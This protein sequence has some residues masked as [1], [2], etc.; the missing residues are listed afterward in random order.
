MALLLVGVGCRSD[1]GRT[2]EPPPAPAAAAYL[3]EAQRALHRADFASALALVDSAEH[4]ATSDQAS[5]QADVHFL[6]GRIFSEAKRYDEA[7]TAYR[8]AL[9]LNPD[10]RGAWFNLGNNAFRQQQYREAVDHYRRERAAHPSPALLVNLGRA[11][12]EL[13]V[14]DS[15]RWAY[16]EA[17][18]ADASE[19]SAY[20][21]LS[22]LYEDEGRFEDALQQA[23]QALQRDPDNLNYRYLVGSLL[24]QTGQPEA[25]LEHLRPVAEQ[26]P[27]HAAAQ[28]NLGQALIRLGRTDEAQRY[29]AAADSA[30][31]LERDVEQW[32]ALVAADPDEPARWAT[33]AHALRSAGRYDEATRA[34]TSALSLDPEHLAIRNQLASLYLELGDAAS[35][36]AHYQFILQRRP[37]S[38]ET[39]LGLGVALAQQGQLDKARQAWQTVLRYAPDHAEAK[40]YLARLDAPS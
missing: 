28:Y 38:A 7:E 3:V 40:A 32:T 26:R 14:A 33:L 23:Q 5:F 35:A 16:E 8:E 27:Q 13:G 20:A 2:S 36:Q 21:R 29:L 10:V 31:A 1:A 30:R 22:Q 34:Y 39:W 11:Y 6:R 25:A 12:A 17:I 19:P 18:A 4:H 15:A 9:A 24:L 37:E